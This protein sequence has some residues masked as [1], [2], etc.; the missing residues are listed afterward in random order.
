[1]TTQ[2][3][4]DKAQAAKGF[5]PGTILTYTGKK[6]QPLEPRP[7]DICIEDI[8]HALSNQCRYTGHTNR[9][10]SVAEHFCLIYDYLK[11]LGCESGITVRWKDYV[12]DGVVVLRWALVH[13]GDETYML[14]LAAPLKHHPNGFGEAFKE[15]AQGILE[16]VANRFDLELPEPPIVKELDLRLRVNEMEQMPIRS[17]T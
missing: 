2:V 9:F 16:A 12:V 5:P 14:D 13:D 3:V 7:E 15:A 17:C 1:M 6:F 8:A 11:R 4:L 10:Y